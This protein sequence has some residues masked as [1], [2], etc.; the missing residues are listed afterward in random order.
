M[1]NVLKIEQVDCGEGRVEWTVHNDVMDTREM[2][3]N[4]KQT[5]MLG[6]I[7]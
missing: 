7:P 4:N 2:H 6:P 5:L 1:S 3:S